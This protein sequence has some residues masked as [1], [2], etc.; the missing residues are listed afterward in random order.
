MVGAEAEAEE[1]VAEGVAAEAQQPQA[2][3][4]T[5]PNHHKH[6]ALK[7]QHRRVISA[8]HVLKSQP[9]HHYPVTRPEAFRLFRDYTL[10]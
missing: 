7:P 1:V 5:R 9:Y 2:Q 6:S 3:A 10:K 4:K 8:Y